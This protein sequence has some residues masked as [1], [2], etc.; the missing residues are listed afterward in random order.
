MNIENLEEG[1]I[2]SVAMT[3]GYAP[4]ESEKLVE[5]EYIIG[6]VRKIDTTNNLIHV[7]HSPDVMVYPQYI[8]GIPL[9]ELVLKRLGWDEIEIEKINVPKQSLSSIKTGYQRAKHQIFQEYDGRFYYIRS[10]SCPV[11]PVEYVH[12]LQK[13]GINDLD[14]SKLLSK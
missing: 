7:T 10:R 14:P 3:V 9:S 11:E 13:L 4:E 6:K 1:Q 2:V 5:I 12:D 8:Q